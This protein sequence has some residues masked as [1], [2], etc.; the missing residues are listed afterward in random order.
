MKLA[1]LSFGL[2]F[3]ASSLHME[4]NGNFKKQN[5]QVAHNDEGTGEAA[6]PNGTNT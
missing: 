5:L 3:L 4:H 6:L 2:M 1:L